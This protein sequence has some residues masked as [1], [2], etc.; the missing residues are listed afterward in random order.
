MKLAQRYS[1]QM[2][3]GLRADVLGTVTRSRA[4]RDLANLGGT[5]QLRGY[6]RSQEF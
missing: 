2:L 1:R 3:T 5:L 6:S 4:A